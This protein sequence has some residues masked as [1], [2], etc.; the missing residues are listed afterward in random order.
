RSGHSNKEQTIEQGAIRFL[1]KPRDIFAFK[2]LRAVL[3]TVDLDFDTPI[4]EFS[5]EAVE[6]LFEGG[7]DTKYDVSYDFR[8]DNVTYKHSFKGLRNI[9]RDQYKESKSNKKR[10][11]AKAYMSRIDCPECE[12]GRLN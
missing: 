11:K 8:Q 6:L 7:G 4:S 2:Q 1:G 10:D 12:G 3:K 9:I 5:D